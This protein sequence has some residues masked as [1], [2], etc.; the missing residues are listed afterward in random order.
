MLADEAGTVY[1][2]G[3]DEA[4]TMAELA[5]AVGDAAGTSVEYRDLP[6]DEYAAVLIGAGLP[7]GYAVC[8]GPVRRRHLAAATSWSRPATS[9]A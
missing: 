2:L 9:A 5:A 8:P 4:F 7:E 3:G 1:E 6:E